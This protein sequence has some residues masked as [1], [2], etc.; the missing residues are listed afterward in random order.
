MISS[1]FDNGFAPFPKT[2]NTTA[3]TKPD[4]GTSTKQASQKQTPTSPASVAS[5][6][7]YESGTSRTSLSTSKR[8]VRTDPSAYD[9]R[10]R[11]A[12][13]RAKDNAFVDTFVNVFNALRTLGVNAGQVATS[14]GVLK[15]M[16]VVDKNVVLALKSVFHSKSM[17]TLPTALA[18][19]LATAGA[20]L[21]IVSKAL[22]ALGGMLSVA[23]AL[24]KGNY[25]AA[26][27][28]AYKAGMSMSRTLGSAVAWNAVQTLLKE[29]VPGYANSRFASFLG[30]LDLINLG[31]LGV[32]A[33][34]VLVKQW[35]KGMSIK[36]LDQL[37]KTM[38]KSGAGAF[39][40][41]GEKAGAD[42]YDIYHQLKTSGRGSY[43]A[44]VPEFWQRWFTR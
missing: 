11:R 24:K 1:A 9:R 38:K 8:S 41:I 14:L 22:T 39:V 6:T 16:G 28:E 17:G 43:Q 37:V 23:V 40:S 44:Y 13:I 21:T 30:A 3:S 34:G 33:I 31:G 26:A 18:K 20:D 4:T 36:E 7:S 32:E 5:K 29:L 42:A 2:S 12:R 35:K 19:K 10:S 15:K 25:P 27:A